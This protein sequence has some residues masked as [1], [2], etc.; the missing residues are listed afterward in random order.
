M[1]DIHL[2]LG[3][4]DHDCYKPGYLNIDLYAKGADQ[5][6]DISLPFQYESNSISSIYCSHAIE[7]LSRDEW[8]RALPEW[9]RLLKK[10][11]TL[12]LICPDLEASI[13]GYLH[14]PSRRDWWIKTLF[15]SQ[16]HPGQFH[17]NGFTLSQL[18]DDLISVG[19]KIIKSGKIEP[20]QLHLI[21]VK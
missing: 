13:I 20:A 15:G 16:S 8:S 3:S 9:Y 12:E 7:H 5:I 11:G 2:N 17:K 10:T 4:G 1:T 6:Q 21:G 19:F 14:E 18:E